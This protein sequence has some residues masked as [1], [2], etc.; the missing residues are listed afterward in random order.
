MLEGEVDLSHLR[1][2]QQTILFAEDE[3]SIRTLVC[4]ILRRHGYNVLVAENGKR[5]L[6]IAKA[7]DGPIHLLLSDVMMPELDGPNLAE[8]LRA[9]RP[10]VRVIFMSGCSSKLLAPDG[11]SGFIQKPFL[12]SALLSMVRDALAQ[13]ANPLHKMVMVILVLENDPSV[14]FLIRLILQPSGHTLVEVGTAEEAFQQFEETGGKVDLLITNV[15]LPASSGIRVGL[16]L[17]A[18]YPRLRII[19][20]SGDATEMWNDQDAAEFNEIPSDSVVVLQ[21][22][23]LPATLL[24]K[25]TR[26]MP[27][28]PARTKAA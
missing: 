22:P 7:L 12:P 28:S 26:F 21:R 3:V 16:G 18:L 6:E 13:P 27:R 4:S 17:R 10:F 1:P 5:A 14:K 9:V 23:F 15:S 24:D 11:E 25:V 8:Q 2:E 19:L 20:T